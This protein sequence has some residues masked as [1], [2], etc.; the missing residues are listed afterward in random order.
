MVSVRRICLLEKVNAIA[1][2]A[3]LRTR[4]RPSV[5]PVSMFGPLFTR[6]GPLRAFR[7]LFLQKYDVTAVGNSF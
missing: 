2:S 3:I 5:I 4:N 6:L 7:S 1:V